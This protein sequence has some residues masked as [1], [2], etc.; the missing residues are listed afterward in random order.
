MGRSAL[1]T[2]LRSFHEQCLT[3]F[4]IRWTTQ[5]W[6][7]VWGHTDSM[8]SPNPVSPSQQ[9]TSPNSAAAEDLETWGEILHGVTF[10]VVDAEG[11][12]VHLTQRGLEVERPGRG[13]V[14]VNPNDAL[15]VR[16]RFIEGT[17]SNS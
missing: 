1:V 14:T 15:G 10:E 5:V 13:L 8:A 9:A 2:A 7:V 12:A 4:L 17:V 6:T 11:A 3:E 16:F